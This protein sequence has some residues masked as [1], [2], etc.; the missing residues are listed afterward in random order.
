MST[1]SQYNINVKKL[2]ARWQVSVDVQARH[3]N[4]KHKPM[5]YK[6]GNKVYLN[7]KNIELTR[8]AKKLDY[9]YYELYI[10]SEAIRKQAYNLKLLPSI[11][12]HNIFHVLLLKPYIGTN[13]PNNPSSSSIEIEEEEEYEVEEILDSCIHYNKL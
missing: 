1:N 12:I 6:I 7:S 8:P 11:N 5:I 2:K 3:Y 13:E 10:I 4:K 9:K